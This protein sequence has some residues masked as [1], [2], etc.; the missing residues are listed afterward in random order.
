MNNELV[1]LDGAL[2]QGARA[3]PGHKSIDIADSLYFHALDLCSNAA[4]TVDAFPAAACLFI[5]LNRSAGSSGS[6][7]RN[8]QQAVGYSGDDA[9]EAKV[10]DPSLWEYHD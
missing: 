9:I 4:P 8:R 2:K 1:K 3:P 6:Y 10:L 5:V 7:S